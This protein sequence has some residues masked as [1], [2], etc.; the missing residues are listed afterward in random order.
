[1]LPQMKLNTRD[2][3]ALIDAVLYSCMFYILS[4]PKTYNLTKSI[5]PALQD[6]NLL[7]AFVFLVGVFLIQKYT[8][9]V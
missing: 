4:H 8:K 1:M 2:K 3:D 7:H 9:R 5:T 6:R